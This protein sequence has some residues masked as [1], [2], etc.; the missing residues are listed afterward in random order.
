MAKLSLSNQQKLFVAAY[1]QCGD[2]ERAVLAA[3][4]QPKNT[5]HRAEVLLSNPYIQQEL[6]HA[7]RVLAMEPMI[8]EAMRLKQARTPEVECLHKLLTGGGK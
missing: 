2:A 4:Y 6:S 3:G 1:I 5:Q 7:R 8:K